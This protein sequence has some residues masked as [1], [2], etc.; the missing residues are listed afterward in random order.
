MRLRLFAVALACLL[1]GA[2]QAAPVYLDTVTNLE[3]RQVKDTVGFSFNQMNTATNGTPAHGCSAATGAC[4]GNLGVTGPSLDGWRW[5]TEEEVRTLY[6]NFSGPLNIPGF[7]PLPG[8]PSVYDEMNSAWAEALVLKAP[9][10]FPND[11]GIFETTSEF[12]G[13]AAIDGFS[14]TLQGTEAF[15]PNLNDIIFGDDRASTNRLVPTN[16]AFGGI[17]FW[18][19]R[20]AEEASVPSPSSML[21][22]LTGLAALGWRRRASDWSRRR[23]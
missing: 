20:D 14:R 17:G 2:A 7:D 19:F 1:S 11:V 4:S 23:K 22:L 9:N 3:W 16:H 21:L 8:S 13:L 6:H 5:A 15:T 10:P 12:A 18:L